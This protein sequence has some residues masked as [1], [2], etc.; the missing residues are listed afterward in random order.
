MISA[1]ELDLQE[2]DNVKALVKDE[3]IKKAFG[4]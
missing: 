3:F 1:F 2:D 4:E